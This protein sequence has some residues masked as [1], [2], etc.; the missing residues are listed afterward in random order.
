MGLPVNGLIKDTLVL[1]YVCNV[2]SKLKLQVQFEDAEKLHFDIGA[3][4]PCGDFPKLQGF[5]AMN[6]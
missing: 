6:I 4:S 2:R 3:F 1:L 5:Y